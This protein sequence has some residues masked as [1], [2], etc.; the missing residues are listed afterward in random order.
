MTQIQNRL[1]VFYLYKTSSNRLDKRVTHFGWE[2]TRDVNK[3]PLSVLL[4]LHTGAR[5]TTMKEGDDQ[6]LVWR[7]QR[8]RVTA[9]EPA[10]RGS[11]LRKG[12]TGATPVDHRA[13]L[14][15]LLC[16]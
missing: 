8:L 9:L 14:P 6:S 3:R 1:F 7:E 16:R 11:E 4:R 15:V 5:P 10:Q 12:V 13:M 2:P